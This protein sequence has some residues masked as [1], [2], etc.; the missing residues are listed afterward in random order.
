M[1]S[2]AALARDAA[3]EAALARSSQLTRSSIA[4]EEQQMSQVHRESSVVRTESR[5][6]GDDVLKT[7]ADLHMMPWSVGHELDEAQSASLRAR[8]RIA[9]LEKELDEITKRALTTSSYGVRKNVDTSV[10]FIL[11]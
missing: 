5:R 8:T 6:T 9:N 3:S 10:Y 7:V 11:I 2:E 1:M 4:R